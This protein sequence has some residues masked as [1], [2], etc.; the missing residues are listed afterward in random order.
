MVSFQVQGLD[1]LQAQLLEIG[2]ELGQKTLAAA[3]RKAFAP[4][5]ERAKSL[6]PVLSGDLRDALRLTVT[7]P[8]SGD[9]VV[10]VGMRVAHTKGNGKELPADRRWHF[11]ELGTVHM[12]P[13][14]FARPALDSGATGV[15][16]TLKSE[17]AKGIERAIKRKARGAK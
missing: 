7:K 4:I 2:A 8:K 3:A 9:V 11:V 10:V 16:E 6:V 14:P 15:I 13:H 5:V 1:V 12:A 17:L